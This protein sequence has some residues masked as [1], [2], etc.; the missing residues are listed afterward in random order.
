MSKSFFRHSIGPKHRY[1][2]KL[3]ISTK[4]LTSNAIKNYK[5]MKLNSQYMKLQIGCNTKYKLKIHSS[6]IQQKYSLVM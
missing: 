1:I 2:S 6:Q 4:G 5:I 3:S